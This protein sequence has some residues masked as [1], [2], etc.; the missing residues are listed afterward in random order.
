MIAVLTK[1]KPHAT[2]N[3]F[4]SLMDE[5]KFVVKGNGNV[6]IVGFFEPSQDEQFM[7]PADFDPEEDEED[8]EDEEIDEDELE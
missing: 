7:N 4:I 6:H 2:L 8:E 5:V 3:I 1:E